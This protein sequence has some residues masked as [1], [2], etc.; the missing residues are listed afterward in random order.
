MNIEAFVSAGLYDP[1]SG[2][3]AAVSGCPVDLVVAA[4]QAMGFSTVDTSVASSTRQT[5]TSSRRS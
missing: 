5:R 1:D 2:K 4:R 3:A